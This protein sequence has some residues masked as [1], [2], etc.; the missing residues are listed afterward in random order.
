MIENQEQLLFSQDRL[1]KLKS[2][3]KRAVDDLT[4]DPRLKESKL[5]GIRGL[6]AEIER[7]I[8]VYNMSRLQNTLDE[9]EQKAQKISIEQVPAL[10]SQ[11]IRAMRELTNAIQPVT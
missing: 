10:L 5:A 8:Y 4:L 11:T 7:E 2:W 1:E 6:M 3:E 9:L